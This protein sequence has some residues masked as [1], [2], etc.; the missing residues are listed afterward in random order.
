MKNSYTR[1]CVC[2]IPIAEIE[3]DIKDGKYILKSN[4]IIN[5]DVHAQTV[6]VYG[7][8]IGDIKADEVVLINGKCT[9]NIHADTVVGLEQPQKKEKN[10]QTCKYYDP[11]WLCFKPSYRHRTDFKFCDNYKEKQS[12]IKEV[13][14]FKNPMTEHKY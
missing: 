4:G 14:I 7:N 9:G 10:C 6:I 11:I 13:D 1:L 2:G 8:V 5:T 3:R 12:S